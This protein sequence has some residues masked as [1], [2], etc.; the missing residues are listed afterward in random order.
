M[1]KAFK[2]D[3]RPEVFSLEAVEF[4]NVLIQCCTVKTKAPSILLQM[5]SSNR[6]AAFSSDY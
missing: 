4:T 6:A 1:D 5:V 3:S 2:Y